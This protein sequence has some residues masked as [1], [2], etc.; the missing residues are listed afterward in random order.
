[1]R[2]RHN[3]RVSQAPSRRYGSTTNSLRRTANALCLVTWPLRSPILRVLLSVSE[4]CRVVG[5]KTLQEVCGTFIPTLRAV[6]TPTN[7]C[8][9][10]ACARSF[11]KPKSGLT[12]IRDCPRY[13]YVIYQDR[14]RGLSMRRDFILEQLLG[15][16]WMMAAAPTLI[17]WRATIQPHY[18]WGLFGV[19]GEGTSA[20]YFWLILPLVALG[21]ANFIVGTRRPEARMFPLLLLAWN[22]IW[23][24]ASLYGA[25]T[26]GDRMTIRGDALGVSVAVNVI[27]PVASGT[28]LALSIYWIAARRGRLRTVEGNTRVTRVLMIA[29]LAVAPLSRRCLPWERIRALGGIRTGIGRP[30][31]CSLGT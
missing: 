17:A 25:L 7:W 2:L 8:R 27:A 6:P 24:G 13:I 16:D 9:R 28:L 26:L 22:G 18:Q 20:G 11:D 10:V 23:F 15:F 1:M 5:L 31:W 12:L 21:W 4:M 30:F 19:T 29:G 14:Q 3:Q